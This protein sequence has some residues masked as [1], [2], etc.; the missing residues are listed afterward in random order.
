MYVLNSNIG[1]NTGIPNG[2]T[3][4][5]FIQSKTACIL[6]ADRHDMCMILTQKK[7][8]P[9]EGGFHRALVLLPIPNNKGGWEK[10]GSEWL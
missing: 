9:T 8:R 3:K 5:F 7:E 4:S 6:R 1:H 10:L 2:Q